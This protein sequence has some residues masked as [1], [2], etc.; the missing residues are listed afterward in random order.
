MRCRTP[1]QKGNSSETL[2]A[3]QTESRQIALLDP[4]FPARISRKPLP[5]TTICRA[6][7]RPGKCS[8]SPSPFCGGGGRSQKSCTIS[9]A[10]RG[11]RRSPPAERLCQSINHRPGKDLRRAS[12]GRLAAHADKP[13]G[14]PCRGLKPGHPGFTTESRA[15]VA[16]T[17]GCR[18]RVPPA[19]HLPRQS[20]GQDSTAGAPP[21]CESMGGALPP[22][23][24]GDS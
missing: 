2:S 4:F 15:A 8:G 6:F 20:R 17:G 22:A 3:R 12:R 21:T 10:S 24:R 18:P 14:R 11:P 19:F 9:V 23:L 7:R 16:A 5:Q 1:S 13:G